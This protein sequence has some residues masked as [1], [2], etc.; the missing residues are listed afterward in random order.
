M[1]DERGCFMLRSKGFW[2][3]MMAGSLAGWVFAIRGL[4][5]PYEHEGIKRIWKNILL[6]WVVGHPLELGLAIPAGK[7]AGISVLKTVL[8]TMLFGFTWWVPVSL[9][10]FRK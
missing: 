4:I 8:K 10:V 7:A 3:L 9:K 1:N 6:G 5:R 2:Y